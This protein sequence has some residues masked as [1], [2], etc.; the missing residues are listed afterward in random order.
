MIKIVVGV[1]VVAAVLMTAPLITPTK[2][3][4]VKL[5]QGVDVQVGRDRNYRS[6]YDRD[7][8]RRYDSGTTVGIGPGGV[9]IG[10]REHCRTVT[11]TTERDD[12]RMITHRERRCD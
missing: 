3:Q 12:G 6:D 4:G 7:H 8:R 1:P 10:P 2:A 9:R 5:A 11:T